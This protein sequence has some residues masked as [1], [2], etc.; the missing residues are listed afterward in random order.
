MEH[1]LPIVVETQ[2]TLYV[3]HTVAAVSFLNLNVFYEYCA[4][5][6]RQYFASGAEL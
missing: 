6:V 3:S 5:A 4:P 2:L 1:A